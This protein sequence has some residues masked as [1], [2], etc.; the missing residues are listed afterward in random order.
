MGFRFHRSIK[1]FPGLRM[2]IS[3]SGLG[4][5]AGFRGFH[6]SRSADGRTR[7]TVSIPGTGMSWI[8][9][10]PAGRPRPT[11]TRADA[12]TTGT[13]PPPPLPPLT[14]DERALC[15]A[16]RAHDLDRITAL[17]NGSTP[18]AFAAKVVTA[19][20]LLAADRD[21]E[22]LGVLEEVFATGR[23]PMIDP[24]VHRHLDVKISIEVT[25]GAS[26]EVEPD[27]TTIGLFLGELYQ[28]RGRVDQAI[29]VVHG[30]PRTTLTALSLADLFDAAGRFDDVID[31]TEDAPNTDDASSLLW[32]LRGVA[33]GEKK[34]YPAAYPCFAKVIRCTSRN[35][36]VLHRARFER[37]RCEMAEGKRSRARNDLGRIMAE[38]A[39]FPGVAAALAELDEPV[40]GSR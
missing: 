6:I 22:A 26:V 9:R 37:A 12:T 24:F 29:D 10:E 40:D 11:R 39:D 27:R 30:L 17:G 16:V 38:D 15:D 20:D 31:V 2:N 33:F 14:P 5:S 21:D 35:P 36:V 3:K 28:R 1:L 19:L 32:V 25:D 13:R 7:R 8:T 4:F 23:D 18:V 34:L